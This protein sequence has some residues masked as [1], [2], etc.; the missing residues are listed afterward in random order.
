[1]RPRG[2]WPQYFRAE[3]QAATLTVRPGWGAITVGCVGGVGVDVGCV[4]GW[5]VGTGKGS[6]NGGIPGIVG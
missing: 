2:S 5:L 6:V 4:V 3:L 1:M